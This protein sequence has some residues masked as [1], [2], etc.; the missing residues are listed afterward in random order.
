M[1]VVFEHHDLL[2][3]ALNILILSVQG[4]LIAEHLYGD[5][6]LSGHFEATV[7]FSEATPA[8]LI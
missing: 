3:H 1:W 7:D 2:P 4:Y 6:L 5:D 8:D